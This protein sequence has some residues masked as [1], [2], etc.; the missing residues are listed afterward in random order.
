MFFS[1][2]VRFLVW[3]LIL[4]AFFSWIGRRTDG[5]AG[6]TAQKEHDEEATLRE[7]AIREHNRRH[8]PSWTREDDVKP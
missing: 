3:I 2:M 4:A 1:L 7:L 8:G 6:R 5:T